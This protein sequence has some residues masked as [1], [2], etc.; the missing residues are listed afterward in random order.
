LPRVPYDRICMHEFVC[1]GH[2]EGSP[3]RALD[4][5]KRPHGAGP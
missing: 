4:I 3:V 5:A 1:E 2:I